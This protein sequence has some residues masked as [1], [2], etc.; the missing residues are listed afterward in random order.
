MTNQPYGGQD[1]NYG[2]QSQGYDQPGYGQPAQGESGYGQGGYGQPA[3]G[4]QGYGQP[5]AGE[6]GATPEF[7]GWGSRVGAYLVDVLV[8]LIFVVPAVI[9]AIATS[10]IDPVTGTVTASPAGQGITLLLYFAAFVVALW[11]VVWRQG[12]TGQSLGKSALGIKLAG[13][14]TG[15]PI[16][17][18]MSFVRQL[19]HILDTLAC[20]IGYLWPL[21]DSKKQTFAD[22]VTSTYVVR[23]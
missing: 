12:R 4:Q 10:D 11:N 22:K 18:G 8:Q 6:F 7:A 3:Y 20:F 23:A 21:W 9:V 5:A 15:Q 16:G 14:S 19:A 17:A 13:A 2:Q 1:P